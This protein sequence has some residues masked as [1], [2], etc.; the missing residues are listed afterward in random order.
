M[1]C[2]RLRYENLTK[3]AK[4]LLVI[5]NAVSFSLGVAITAITSWLLSHRSLFIYLNDSNTSIE[6]DTVDSEVNYYKSFMLIGSS[7]IIGAGVL[8]VLISLIGI[9]GALKESKCLLLTYTVAVVLLTLIQTITLSLSIAFKAELKDRTSRFMLWTL[10]YYGSK[11]GSEHFITKAWNVEMEQYE[12]C[13]VNGYKD[14][15]NHTYIDKLP[16]FCCTEVSANCSIAYL[17]TKLVKSAPGCLEEMYNSVLNPFS[18]DVIILSI[19]VF[20]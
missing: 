2:G 18:F 7:T 4:P 1:C 12:C 10:R 11:N 5:L 13:G 3:L 8:I 20:H 17:S 6:K 19:L 9:V 14:F 16:Q 15:I